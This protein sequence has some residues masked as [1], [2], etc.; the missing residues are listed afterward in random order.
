MVQG[1]H[2]FGLKLIEIILRFEIQLD[3]SDLLPSIC[4]VLSV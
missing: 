4:Q 3:N 2:D 1:C